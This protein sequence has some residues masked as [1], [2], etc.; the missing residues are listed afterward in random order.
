MRVLVFDLDTD[1]KVGYAEWFF[2]ATEA[3]GTAFCFG[4]LEF[5]TD[6]AFHVIEAVPEDEGYAW[7]REHPAVP[8]AIDKAMDIANK[9]DDRM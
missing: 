9:K 1:R 2:F 3:E 5:G 6:D 7:E 8:G 4:V